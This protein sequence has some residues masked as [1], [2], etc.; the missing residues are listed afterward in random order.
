MM[1]YHHVAYNPVNINTMT[2]DA[3]LNP[4]LVDVST[5]V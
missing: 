1:H 5:A 3:Q 2:S 4:A